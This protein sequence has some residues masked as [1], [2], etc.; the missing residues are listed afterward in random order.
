MRKIR[1]NEI[2]EVYVSCDIFRNAKART[3]KVKQEDMLNWIHK[4]PVT[5]E[6]SQKIKQFMVSGLKLSI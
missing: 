4:I 1:K 3:D 5:M 2:C 6:N